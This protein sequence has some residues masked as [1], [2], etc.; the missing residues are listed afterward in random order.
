M[1]SQS[2]QS[3]MVSSS[4]N[5]NNSSGNTTR[6]IQLKYN[7]KARK[8]LKRFMPSKHIEKHAKDAENLLTCHSTRL[9]ARK[10]PR[11]ERYYTTM[12]IKH[13]YTILAIALNLIGDDIQLVDLRRFIRE[14][15]LSGKNVIQ[16][17]PENLKPHV[18]ELL[19]EIEFYSYADTV[20]YKVRSSKYFCNYQ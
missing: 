18:N 10:I 7:S 3:S 8:S 16:Y 15:H 5:S 6:A 2:S 14:S 1:Y 13:L 12:H 11:L 17:F 9:P 20:S 4:N 19:S